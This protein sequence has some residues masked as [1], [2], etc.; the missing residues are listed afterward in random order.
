LPFYQE[1]ILGGY[2][3]GKQKKRDEGQLKNHAG[4]KGPWNA[5][6]VIRSAG[7]KTL[8]YFTLSPDQLVAD[9]EDEI[10]RDKESSSD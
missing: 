3:W 2:V 9:Y 7:V 8:E 1:C 6:L 10:P 4:K 5:R